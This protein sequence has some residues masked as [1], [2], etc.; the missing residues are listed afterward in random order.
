MIGLY[1]VNNNKRE[2]LPKLDPACYKIKNGVNFVSTAGEFKV[3]D[4]EYLCR[5]AVLKFL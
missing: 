3:G 1:I 5:I 2:K 4:I